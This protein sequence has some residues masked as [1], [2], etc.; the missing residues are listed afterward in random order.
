MPRSSRCTI[1]GRSGSDPSRLGQRRRARGTGQAGR[2]PACP[3]AVTGTGMDHQAG[4]LV[5]HDQVGGP[6]G[7]PRTRPRGRRPAGP[8]ELLVPVDPQAPGRSRRVVLRLRTVAPSIRHPS[9]VDQGVDRR[10]GTRRPAG[11]P[12]CPPGPRR[13]TAGTVD[14]SAAFTGAAARA[15]SET[16]SS[17]QPT[18]MRGV[19]HVEGGPEVE[20]HEV[21]HRPVVA[22]EE[23]VGRDCPA[24]PRGSARGWRPGRSSGPARPWHRSTATST[25]ATG[26]STKAFPWNRLKD[27]PVLRDSSRSSVPITWIGPEARRV[28]G[29]PLGQLVGQDHDGRHRSGRPPSARRRSRGRPLVV[30]SPRPAHRS[31]P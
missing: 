23:A 10:T 22:P 18:T 20:G 16:R 1:P 25:T 2:G 30:R 17:R 19:G 11:P 12:P 28:D 31:A 27:A 24:P 21:D 5:H 9:L 4:R 29:P 8:A 3:V 13:A 7:P 26:T 14:R 15:A 6:R